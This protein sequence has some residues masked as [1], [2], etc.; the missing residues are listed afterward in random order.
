MLKALGAADLLPEVTI[1]GV[2]GALSL[3][4]SILLF[5]KKLG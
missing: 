5:N 2:G 3:G 4:A 1:L